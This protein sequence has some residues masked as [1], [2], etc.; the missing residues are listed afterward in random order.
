MGLKNIQTRVEYLKGSVEFDS[1]T[2]QGTV[3]SIH[4]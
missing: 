1:T 4:I 2:G 3:V